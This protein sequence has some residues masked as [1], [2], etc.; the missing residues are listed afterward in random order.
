MATHS[1]ILTW[2]IPWT[3]GPG[4]L[5][6]MGLQRVRYSWMTEHSTTPWNLCMREEKRI[7][8]LECLGIL[9]KKK[10][11]VASLGRHIKVYFWHPCSGWENFRHLT[12]ECTLGQSCVRTLRFQ[13]KNLNQ[14]LNRWSWLLV[15]RYLLINVREEL[16]KGGTVFAKCLGE[17]I[18]IKEMSDVWQQLKKWVLSLSIRIGRLK[19]NIILQ[20][21]CIS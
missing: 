8:G 12:Q 10:V 2:K 13:T 16:R 11:R 21:I 14:S 20:K 6:V 19:I 18:S 4:S 15:A 5:Q 9:Q 1:S 3:E 7:G 17:N